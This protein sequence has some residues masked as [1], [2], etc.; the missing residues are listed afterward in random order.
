MSIGDA[1][2]L[3]IYLIVLSA[4]LSCSRTVRI[5]VWQAIRHPLSNG[6]ILYHHDGAVEY[7]EGNYSEESAD[8]PS[9]TA[10]ALPRQDKIGPVGV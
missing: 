9:E 8:A 10:P 2:V 3:G 4:M 5:L 1:I 7:V 6:T